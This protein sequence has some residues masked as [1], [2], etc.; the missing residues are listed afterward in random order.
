MLLPKSINNEKT[1]VNSNFLSL[2]PEDN[3]MS[4]LIKKLSQKIVMR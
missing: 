4:K 3:L 2:S 1:P